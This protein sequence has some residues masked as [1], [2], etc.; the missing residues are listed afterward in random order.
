VPFP[1]DRTPSDLRHL[2]DPD[3]GGAARAWQGAKPDL[4][5]YRERIAATIE[6]AKAEEPP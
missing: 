3:G 4:A 1:D 5:K 2:G 6:R